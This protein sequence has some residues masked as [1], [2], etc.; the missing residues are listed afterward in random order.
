MFPQ[1]RAA[2]MLVQAEG[3]RS[4]ADADP[5]IRKLDM[6]RVPALIGMVVTCCF[7][8]RKKCAPR[9]PSLDGG[10]IAYYCPTAPRINPATR[11]AHFDDESELA[12]GRMRGNMER[13]HASV[14]ACILSTQPSST[15]NKQ[16][17]A[18]C[19]SPRTDKPKQS[20]QTRWMA[21]IQIHRMSRTSSR[22]VCEAG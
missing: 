19:G 1:L 21:S 20:M 17:K 10:N 7:I 8:R 14:C 6:P 3:R 4:P 18:I 16:W 12:H 5:P 15:A 22:Q 13:M 9:A 11:S 2:P